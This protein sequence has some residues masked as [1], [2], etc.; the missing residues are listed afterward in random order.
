MVASAAIGTMQTN[1]HQWFGQLLRFAD[2]RIAASPEIYEYF[3][4]NERQIKTCKWL[5]TNHIPHYM[6]Y[7]NKNISEKLLRSAVTYQ[8]IGLIP[9]QSTLI[10]SLTLFRLDNLKVAPLEMRV[11][12]IGRYGGRTLLNPS[13]KIN[14]TGDW[15]LR[16]TVVNSA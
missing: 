12:Q 5:E 1:N 6:Q 16:Y 8:R 4:M 13:R 14:V 15:V 2:I 10:A 3:K 11:V 7:L 9:E